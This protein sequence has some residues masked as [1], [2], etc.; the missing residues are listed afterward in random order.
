MIA[1]TVTVSCTMSDLVESCVETAVIVGVAA[2]VNAGVK[3][4]AVPEVTFAVAL[5]VPVDA[6]LT[7]RF[8][9]F[10]N[11]PVPVTVGVQLV[12]CASV[13]DVVAHFSEALVIVDGAAVIVSIA[14]FEVVI[15]V[16][17]DVATQLAD[18]TVVFVMAPVVLLMV[19]LPVIAYV[20]L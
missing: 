7:E 20:T 4:T 14:A 15:G 5:N 18:P 11:D 8:T 6:G 12:V 16:P 13:M 19:A 9:V 10:V 3:V 1:R 2:P 17:T